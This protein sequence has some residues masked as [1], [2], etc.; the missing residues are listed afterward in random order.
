VAGIAVAVF[1]GS[2]P[3][4][5]S[6]AAGPDINMRAATGLSCTAPVAPGPAHPD[7]V[8][9]QLF[10]V[11][12]GKVPYTLG[13][14]IV[15]FKT[16]VRTYRFGAVGAILALEPAT[17]GRPVGYGKGTVTFDRQP[18]AGTVNAVITLKAGASLSVRGSW[19]CALGASTGTTSPPT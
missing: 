19:T 15:P 1:A 14:T 7:V 11:H 18:D 2:G 5:T 17:G 16:T 13:W 8:L 4:T 6:P 12:A 9:S 10:T 3:T